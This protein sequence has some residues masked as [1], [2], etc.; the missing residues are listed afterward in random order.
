M[1]VGSSPGAVTSHSD[2]AAASSNEF[3]EIQA[4][5]ECGFTLKRVRDMAR[6]YSQDNVFWVEHVLLDACFS[7]KRKD[8]VFI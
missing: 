7:F 5:I 1:V 4:T 3:F 6:T 8:L 2:F